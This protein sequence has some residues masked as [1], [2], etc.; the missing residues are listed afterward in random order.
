MNWE[1]LSTEVLYNPRLPKEEMDLLHRA[2][3]PELRGHVWLA[4]S[5][6]TSIHQIKLM[7]LSKKAILE[8]AKVVNEHIKSDGNDKWLNAL[9]SFHMGGLSIDARAYLSGAEVINTELLRWSPIDFFKKLSTYRATLTSLV[10]T[11]VY[12]LVK[13]NFR[14]PKDLRVA[15]VGGAALSEGLYKKAVELGWPLLPTYGMTECGQ[16]ATASLSQIGCG[17]V[18]LLEILPH[19]EVRVSIHGGIEVQ[20]SSLFSMMALIGK[21]TTSII[22]REGAWYPTKDLGEKQGC[23]LVIQGRRDEVVKVGGEM[24]NVSKLNQILNQII[25]DREVE[26]EWLALAH[27]D[28]RLGFRVDLVTTNLCGVDEVVSSFERGVHGFERFHTAYIVDELPKSDIGKVRVGWLKS[29][30]GLRTVELHGVG[31]K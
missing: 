18:P 30:L 26:G 11:Q 23:H 25:I 19:M 24:V 2:E 13:M 22:K 14:A 31:K 9:P 8:S 29:Q 12:D 17:S 28:L 15:F 27:S 16:I 6:T 21:G 5:G 20:S 4:S 10:P 3:L 1:S 7:A